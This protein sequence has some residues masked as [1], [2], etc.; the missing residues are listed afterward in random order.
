[1]KIASLIIGVLLLV[2][3]VGYVVTQSEADP[4]ASTTVVTETAADPTQADTT[5]AAEE[6]TIETN[7]VENTNDTDSGTYQEYDAEAIAK[8]DADRI[9]LSFSA[10][11]CP[12]CRA[13]DADILANASDIP[14]NVEIYKVDYDTAT[15]LKRQYGIT[16]QH[17]IIE[18]NSDGEAVGS[19]THPLDLA[20]LLT[21]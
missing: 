21:A 8:S 4:K 19:I 10:T 1:M 20:S 18:I 7:P 16:V 2:L 17:S 3:G 15:D 13:L 12:S 11:W 9:F 5:S 14:P 6:V